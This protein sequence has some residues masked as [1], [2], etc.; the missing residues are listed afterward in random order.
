MAVLG[1]FVA[2]GAFAITPGAGALAQKAFGIYVGGAGNVTLTGDDG[3]SVTYVGLTAGSFI[4]IVATHVTAAT[5][6][7][8]LGHKANL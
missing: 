4:P 2:R 3:V 6:S 8:L 5:A 1:S 7:N